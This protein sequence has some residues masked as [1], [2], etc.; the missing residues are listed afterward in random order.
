MTDQTW[1][2]FTKQDPMPTMLRLGSTKFDANSTNT[3]P[4]PTSVGP[5]STRSLIHTA[6]PNSISTGF[7][8]GSTKLGSG[9]TKFRCYSTNVWPDVTELDPVW[10]G[11]DE[12]WMDL[13]QIGAGS[14]LA[15][16]MWL[17]KWPAKSSATCSEVETSAAWFDIDPI[18]LGAAQAW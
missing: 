4:D 18:V 13:S 10:E 1:P 16:Q 7:R 12:V 11:I 17:N 2:E 9:P 14:D 5:I 15:A 3:R 6:T 8:P